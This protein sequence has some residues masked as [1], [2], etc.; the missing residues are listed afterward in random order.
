MSG[1]TFRQLA[2]ASVASA[3]L[4]ISLPSAASAQTAAPPQWLRFNVETVKPDMVQEYEG[5][6]KQL[7][8]AYKKAGQPLYAVLSSYSGNRNEY[9]TVTF[10]MKFGDLDSPSPL[11]K[12]LGE[13]AFT[14]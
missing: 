12:A 9:T 7:A 3:M 10:V 5:Y 8:A 6:K 2:I 11:R 13:E 1:T 4:A 14:N